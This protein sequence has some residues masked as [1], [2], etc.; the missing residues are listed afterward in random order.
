M[1]R[2]GATRPLRPR[3]YPLAVPPGACG[4][5]SRSIADAGEPGALARPLGLAVGAMTP[6]LLVG[7]GVRL[8]ESGVP[9]PGLDMAAMNL[10]R[11]SPRP[12]RP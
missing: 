3:A 5:P 1:N 8:A 2:A 11:W 4:T 12:R 9:R 7:L 6:T 10:A